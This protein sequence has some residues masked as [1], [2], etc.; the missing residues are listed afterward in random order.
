LNAQ[1]VAVEPSDSIPSPSEEVINDKEQ[2]QTPDSASALY[3]RPGK[4]DGEGNQEQLARGNDADATSPL[5]L[6]SGHLF[7]PFDSDN[8]SSF[9][10]QA[11]VITQTRV[12]IFP[13][14]NAPQQ[15]RSTSETRTWRNRWP[16]QVWF[17]SG[18]KK[19]YRARLPALRN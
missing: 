16:V 13:L 2:R 4:S 11:S 5:Y 19:A 8:N 18:L 15:Q 14:S 9:H 12:N 10:V 3:S 17:A 1:E 7:N 6:F